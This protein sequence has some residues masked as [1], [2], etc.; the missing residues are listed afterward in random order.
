MENAGNPRLLTCTAC[1]RIVLMHHLDDLDDILEVCGRMPGKANR[2][3]FSSYLRSQLPG[4]KLTTDTEDF[5]FQQVGGY[6]PGYGPL[7]T[8]SIT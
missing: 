7:I 8:R 6:V 3:Q 2:T 5:L 1:N 4:L